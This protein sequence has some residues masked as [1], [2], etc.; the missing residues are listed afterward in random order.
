MQIDRCAGKGS[1]KVY[2]EVGVLEV[3]EIED[4]LDD[5]IDAVVLDFELRAVDIRA[6]TT[7]GE[8]E[9][10][11]DEFFEFRQPYRQG[12]RRRGRNRAGER[13]QGISECSEQVKVD[14]V[15]GIAEQIVQALPDQRQRLV[16]RLTD[17]RA[18]IADQR[19]RIAEGLAGKL[20]RVQQAKVDQAER[21]FLGVEQQVGRDISRSMA[22]DP[23]Q[24]QDLA[25]RINVVDDCRV[26]DRG[27]GI[28]LGDLEQ[29]GCRIAVR[30]IGESVARG[31][32]RHSAVA[33]RRIILELVP[34]F[35]LAR[36]LADDVGER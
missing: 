21:R 33:A 23:Q 19:F 26:A 1:E 22:A 18:D 25:L 4:E 17:P 16:P 30:Q 2:A 3:V 24:P 29:H 10:I 31:E 36:Q 5:P 12:L 11:L 27:G 34:D 35:G 8:P 15:G 20:D 6:A 32:R 13:R 14:P 28:R 7:I 9:R